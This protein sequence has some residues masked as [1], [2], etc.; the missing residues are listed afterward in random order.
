[1]NLPSVPSTWPTRLIVSNVLC[2]SSAWHQG[3]KAIGRV[4]SVRSA[5]SCLRLPSLSASPSFSDRCGGSM[6][7]DERFAVP[8]SPTCVGHMLRCFPWLGPSKRPSPL[9]VH[10][11]RCVRIIAGVGSTGSHAMPGGDHPNCALPWLGFPL[12]SQ[13]INQGGTDSRSRFL[14][15]ISGLKRPDVLHSEPT[16]AA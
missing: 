15:G 14:R 1:M 10:P 9:L 13:Y 6:W 7:Q 12:F 16:R 11:V 5:V 3:P 2:G 4:A 8:G